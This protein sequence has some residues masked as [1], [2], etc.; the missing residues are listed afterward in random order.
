MRTLIKK[1]QLVLDQQA[2]QKAEQYLAIK[3]LLGDAKQ[4]KM[5]VEQQNHLQEIIFRQDQTV[6]QLE[7]KL[8]D[9]NQ[10]KLII[11]QTQSADV[12]HP[13]VGSVPDAQMHD[14]D[15]KMNVTD[16]HGK[17]NVSSPS[18]AHDRPAS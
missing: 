6:K 16:E 2:L 9:L 18:Y 4:Q 7:I 5:L 3:N 10:G 13:H 8:A 11:A 12:V 15:V 1:Q 17:A 14:D